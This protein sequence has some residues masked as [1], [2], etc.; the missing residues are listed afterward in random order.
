MKI[1]GFDF[2]SAPSRTKLITCAQCRLEDDTLHLEAFDSLETF[3]SFE[4]F[5]AHP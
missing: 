2:T 5:L 4:R 3:T 1:Y